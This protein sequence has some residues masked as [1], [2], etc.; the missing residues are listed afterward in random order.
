MLA[1]HAFRNDLVSKRT[2]AR[3]LAEE[4]RFRLG[5]SSKRR[6]DEVAEWAL[7]L[8]AGTDMSEVADI[9]NAVADQI[10]DTVRPALR[11]LLDNHRHAGHETIVLSAS[12]Q[13]LVELVA[14]GLNADAGIGTRVEIVDGK[15]TGEM[16]PPFCYGAAKIDRLQDVLGSIA[17]DTIL[18]AYADSASDLPLLE[19]AEHRIVVTPDKTLRGI[20]E[21]RGWSILD[22]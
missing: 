8:S 12:P 14:K 3:A 10:I 9:T 11:Q 21:S 2:L 20:A 4:S 16:I 5:R 13:P 18:Y 7:R 22:F 15:L 17:T 1:R 6:L 19:I